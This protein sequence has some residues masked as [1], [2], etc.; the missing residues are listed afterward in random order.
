[1]AQRAALRLVQGLGMLGPRDKMTPKAAA[2]LLNRFEEPLTASDIAA[3]A[4]L[5][6]LDCTAP[7]ITAGMAGVIADDA[8][9]SC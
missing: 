5:T 3:I 8:E 1:M 6:G 4:R 2:E 9:T 7:K